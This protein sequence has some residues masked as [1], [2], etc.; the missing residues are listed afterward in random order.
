[1]SESGADILAEHMAECTDAKAAIVVDGSADEIVAR[2][3]AA[4]W[5]MDERVDHVAGKR[6]RFLRTPEGGEG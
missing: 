5:T 1:V 3:L 4:G 2:L 6:I